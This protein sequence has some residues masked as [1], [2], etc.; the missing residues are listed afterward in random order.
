MD[1]QKNNIKS[2]LSPSNHSVIKNQIEVKNLVRLKHI[3]VLLNSFLKNVEFQ[4]V[5]NKHKRM[6]ISIG[7]LFQSEIGSKFVPAINLSQLS[8][9][10]GR[11]EQILPSTLQSRAVCCLEICSNHGNTSY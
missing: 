10:K 8:L 11:N 5:E 9:V 2:L 3:F 6:N 1:E 7:C 4:E